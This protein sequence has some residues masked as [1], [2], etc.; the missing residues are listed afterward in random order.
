MTVGYRAPQIKNYVLEGDGDRRHGTASVYTSH[1]CRCTKCRK[2]NATRMAQ[3]RW[4]MAK[5]GLKPGD[6]RHGTRGGYVNWG[7]R[8]T[9]CSE[10]HK[11]ACKDYYWGNKA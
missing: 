1:G 11:Q 6:P 8:C 10:V 3:Q 2:G 4:R 9:Q 5:V 7:C